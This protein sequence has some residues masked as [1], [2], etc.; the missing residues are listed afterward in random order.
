MKKICTNGKYY[1]GNCSLQVYPGECLCCMQWTEEHTKCGKPMHAKCLPGWGDRACPCKQMFVEFQP[2]SL[3]DKL[4]QVNKLQEENHA[5]K[6]TLKRT[7][8]LQVNHELEETKKRF[9]VMVDN[10]N[11]ASM[12]KTALRQENEIL[13]NENES[14]RNNL[15]IQRAGISGIHKDMQDL[16]QKYDVQV[17][18]NSDLTAALNKKD[19]DIA[20]L[21]ECENMRVEQ[22]NSMQKIAASFERDAIKYQ[23]DFHASETKNVRLQSQIISLNL[24]N[25][26]K[27]V[28]TERLGRDLESKNSIIEHL[29]EE[30]EKL[31]QQL[32]ASKIIKPET[33][34]D[35]EEDTVQEL[36]EDIHED[37]VEESTVVELV[38]PIV[39]PVQPTVV[40]TPPF[41]FGNSRVAPLEVENTT[42]PRTKC[43]CLF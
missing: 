34:Q 11:R 21:K 41:R 36:E 43:F 37:I 19:C 23:K 7:T 18:V 38:Q 1:C 25:K 39:E 33:V 22:I 8:K 27:E 5:L 3:E 32:R 14:L 15:A 35:L 29:K 10:Y 13:K 6:E 42:A 31:K 26:E 40:T 2:I 16:K 24:E 4:E 9:Q 17:K 20:W 30:I 28:L 12:E